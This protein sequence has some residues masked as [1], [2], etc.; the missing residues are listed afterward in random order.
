MNK[1]NYIIESQSVSDDV[2]KLAE[3]VGQKVISITKKQQIKKSEQTNFYYVDGEFKIR[4]NGKLKGGE[5]LTVQYIMYMFTSQEVYYAFL[6]NNNEN[7]NSEADPDTNTIKIVS[8]FIKGG[9]VNDFYETISHELEHLYQYGCGMEKRAELYDK[10]IKLLANGNSNIDAY[11]V[12]LCCY[13]SFKHEQDAFVHQFYTRLK[14][15]GKRG[16]F[17]Y[18]IKDYQPYQTISKAYEVLLDFQDNERIMKAINYLGFTRKQ[19]IN[20]I[21]YRLKR[22]DK[23][24]YN[25]Y[26]RYMGETA[27]LTEGNVDR[28]IREMEDRL[29]ETKKRGYEVEWGLESIYNF[30]P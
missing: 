3:T 19:F 4:T 1:R 24:L 20:L 11:Y 8:A 9:V 16:H 17:D 22:F 2:V 10:A 18:F 14:Q 13:Y 28:F 26:R 30:A 29:K 25:A 7:L 12:G 15:M 21:Y 6:T 5:V 23:K 27:T